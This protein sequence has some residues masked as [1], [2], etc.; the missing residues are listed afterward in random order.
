MNMYDVTSELSTE[1]IGL[2]PHMD[3][4]SLTILHEDD[5][6]GLQVCNRAGHWIDVI[7][8]PNS[9]VAMMGG[10]FQI[11]FITISNV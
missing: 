8:I 10:C 2:Q 11:L 7:P 6:G 4:G 1:I 3:M 5:C 9:F